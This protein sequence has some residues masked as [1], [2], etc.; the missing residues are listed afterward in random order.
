MRPLDL[1]RLNAAASGLVGEH[2]FAAFCKRKEHATTIRA[3]T[4]LNWRRDPDRTCVATVQAD[5]FCQ[6]MVR[7]LV[8]AI[9]TVGDGRRP[10]DWPGRLLTMRERSSE[11][12][13]A[14]AHGLTLVAV[15]YPEEKEYAA[16]AEATRRLRA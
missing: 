9:L 10:P 12:T 6:A 5:A 14:P 8:G 11:V 4:R 7:S 16:R 3:I 13:V 1:D 15:G 2:D